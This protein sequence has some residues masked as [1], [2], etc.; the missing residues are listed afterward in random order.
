M[1]RK[2]DD[3]VLALGMLIVSILLALGFAWAVAVAVSG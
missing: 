2:D 3:T 1:K